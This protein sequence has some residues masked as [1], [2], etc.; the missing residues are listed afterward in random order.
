[1]M[2]ESGARREPATGRQVTPARIPND[3]VRTLGGPAVVV[4]HAPARSAST[5]ERVRQTIELLRRRGYALTPARLGV[6]CLGGELSEEEVRWRVA[7]SDDLAISAVLV[8]DRP[9]LSRLG[10]I[11]ARAGAHDAEAAPY[12]P[13]TARFVRT[14]VAV[15]PFIRSVSVAGSLASG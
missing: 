10:E 9:A 4:D 8:V 5:S 3:R 12:M 7:A 2:P 15:A 14:L 6:V 13:M 11:G 1:M